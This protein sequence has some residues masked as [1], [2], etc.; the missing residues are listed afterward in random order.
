MSLETAFLA[1]ALVL[2]CCGWWKLV[3]MSRRHEREW[4]EHLRHLE[5]IM[6]WRGR[7]YVGEWRQGYTVSANEMMSEPDD[8]VADDTAA[9]DDGRG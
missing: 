7:V 5:Q 2:F 8:T 3:E 4:L 1:G 6:E 9:G